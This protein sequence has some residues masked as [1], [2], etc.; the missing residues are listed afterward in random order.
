MSTRS[1]EN[2]KKRGQKHQNVY[3]FKL[4][5]LSAKTQKILST[6]K[7]H[8]CQRCFDQIQW[9]IDYKKYKPLSQP[10][11]CADCKQKCVFK[12]YRALCEVC[13][14]KKQPV[15]CTPEM[16]KHLHLMAGLVEKKEKEAILKA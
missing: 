2:K 10:A 12:A 9:R 6:P 8:L 11:R 13:A 15:I 4:N 3:K 1:G 7:D 5:E 14:D 16:I